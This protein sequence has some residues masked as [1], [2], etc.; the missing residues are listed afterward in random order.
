[1]PICELFSFAQECDI[2]NWYALIIELIIGGTLAG[3]FF[4]RQQKQGKK[5]QKIIDEQEN[6]RKRRISYASHSI[7][8]YLIALRNKLNQ[9]DKTI[10][11]FMHFPSNSK[12]RSMVSDVIQNEK[13][14][15]FYFADRL[16]EILNQSVDVIDPAILMESRAIIKMS[17]EE[18][19]IDKNG[20][21]HIHE[22]KHEAIIHNIDELLKKINLPS[23]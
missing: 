15:V 3:A 12:E 19:Y 20:N 14:E 13:T 6:F 16:D 9:V 8:S 5:L 21:W 1:M 7:H 2:P 23:L 4:I 18:L 10:S 17:R 22:H 11:M